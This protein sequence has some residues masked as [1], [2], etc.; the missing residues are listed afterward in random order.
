MTTPPYSIKTPP[1]IDLAATLEKSGHK[2]ILAEYQPTSENMV[3]DF[4]E[5]IRGRLPEH[6]Q[7]HSLQLR[8]T[9]TAYAEWYASDNP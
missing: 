1:H 7:L 3:I 9:G 4:A 5:K 2:V 6:L 8:E